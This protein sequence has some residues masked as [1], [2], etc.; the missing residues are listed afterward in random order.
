M[1]FKFIP[2]LALL[3]SGCVSYQH[4]TVTSDLPVENETAR[5][6]TETE[7]L[8]ITFDFNGNNFPVKA[9]IYNLSDSVL[10][11]DLEA[12]SFTVNGGVIANAKNAKVI[13]FAAN[14]LSYEI[15]E[16]EFQRTVGG[17]IVPADQSMVAIPS[18]GNLQLVNHP[19]KRAYDS[20]KRKNF[21]KKDTIII[22]SQIQK[23]KRYDFPKNAGILGAHYL[24][25]TNRKF[26]N[27]KMVSAQ[28]EEKSLYN[29]GA[30]SII[31]KKPETQRYSVY[32]KHKTFGY[33]FMIGLLGLGVYATANSDGHTE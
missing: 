21:T 17:A 16:W 5:Y 19:F 15:N 14:T 22:G 28:F 25:A 24:I 11:V 1:D 3:L 23:S 30:A 32:K 26:E 31:L 13:R 18:Y 10:F 27:A 9:T 8:R 29:S 6:Y 20:K 2:V 7:D 33:I 4:V 12:S